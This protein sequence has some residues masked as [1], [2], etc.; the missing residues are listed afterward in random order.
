MSDPS[1]A[2]VIVIYGICNISRKTISAYSQS[3]IVIYVCR[4]KIMLQQIA[5]YYRT[6]FPME[7]HMYASDENKWFTLIGFVVF[8]AMVSVALLVVY[9]IATRPAASQG[10]DPLD[11]AK[12]RYAKGEINKDE[13]ADIKKQLESK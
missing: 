6:D 9:K 5:Q 10:K 7:H 13:F 3:G 12:E 8:V 1:I 11:I 2:G 4:R